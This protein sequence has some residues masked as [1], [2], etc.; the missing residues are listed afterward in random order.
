M[1][2][3]LNKQPLCHCDYKTEFETI[4]E[5]KISFITFQIVSNLRR[6][7][8]TP[9]DLKLYGAPYIANVHFIFESLIVSRV[10]YGLSVYGSDPTSLRKIDR[11]LERCYEKNFCTFRFD[12][13]TLRQQEDLRNLRRIQTNPNHPLHQYLTSFKKK[14]RAHESISPCFLQSCFIFLI[15]LFQ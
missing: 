3:C 12:I 13:F 8:Y 9:K 4:H 7:L 6:L 2:F 5:T 1:R 14:R 15:F 10:R 11:F